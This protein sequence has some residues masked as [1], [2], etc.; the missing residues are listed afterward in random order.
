M[1]PFPD[2]DTWAE[3]AD[4]EERARLAFGQLYVWYR[5][6]EPEL[7]P[8]YRDIASMPKSRRDGIAARAGRMADLIAG[9]QGGRS[10]RAAAGHLV[11]FFTWRSLAI[12]QRLDDAEAVDL[13]SRF[14]SA[15]AETDGGTIPASTHRTRR[16]T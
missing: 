2:V 13:A 12:D 3:V 9:E 16:P 4:L 11:S 6:K 10:T 14:L 5:E 15:A 1:N 7:Y 8:I